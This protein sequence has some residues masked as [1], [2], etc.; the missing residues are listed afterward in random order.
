VAPSIRLSEMYYIAAEA[1][2]AI[3]PNDALGYYNTIRA[4]RGI[5]ATVTTMPSKAAF[6]DRLLAEARKE[7]YGETQLFYM[8]K[9]LDHAIVVSSTQTILPSDKI[10]VLPIPPD[11]FTYRTN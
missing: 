5:G 9:R 4:K 11:E 3:N 2:F 6:I 8:Y 10:F 1:S 7:F